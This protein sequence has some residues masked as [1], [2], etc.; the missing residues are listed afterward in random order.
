MYVYLSIFYIL[1]IVFYLFNIANKSILTKNIIK[2]I[3]KIK[4]KL[5]QHF[6][7]I[8]KIKELLSV[9]IIFEN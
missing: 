7:T 1:R 8:D 4:T 5:L 3:Q 6:I 9:K 2:I